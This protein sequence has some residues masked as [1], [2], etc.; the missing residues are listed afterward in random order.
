MNRIQIGD[1]IPS[2]TLKDQNGNDFDIST[3]LGRKKLSSFSIH[4]TGA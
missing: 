2:F 1:I 3:L 4:R